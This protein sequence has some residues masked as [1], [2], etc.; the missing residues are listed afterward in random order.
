MKILL[1]G[2]N[3][4]QCGVA[5]V[6]TKKIFDSNNLF[7]MLK[8]FADVDF[9][10]I[11]NNTNFDA[12]DLCVVGLGSIGSFNYADVMNAFY[13]LGKTSKCVMFLEDWRIPKTVAALK[14]TFE[15]G[16]DEFLNKT[17]NKKLRDGTRFYHGTDW[18][19]PEVCWKGIDKLANH[20]DEVHFLMPGFAWGDKKIVADILNTKLEN[21]HWFDQ[22]PILMEIYDIKDIPFNPN[23]NKKYLYC[24]LSNQDQWLKKCGISEITDRFGHSP[25]EKLESETDVNQKHNEYF[26]IAVPRYYHA[27]SGWFRMRYIYSAMAKNVMYIADEDAQALGIPSLKTLDVDISIIEKTANDI[28]SKVKSYIPTKEESISH[29]KDE[30]MKCC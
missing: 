1:T 30:L 29:L 21:V 18:L 17:F 3:N 10:R 7:N 15:K 8:T 12:Y 24:G 14:T 22:T 28:Y 27:G 20:A 11:D 5:K 23:R 13:I 9:S 4:K 26:G 25:Y 2:S 19:D 16:Y 6:H